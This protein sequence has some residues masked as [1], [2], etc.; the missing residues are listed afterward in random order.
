MNIKSH[1]RLRT[2]RGTAPTNPKFTKLATFQGAT[3]FTFDADK[4]ANLHNSLGSQDP[5]QA[6]GVSSDLIMAGTKPNRSIHERGNSMGSSL[7]GNGMISRLFNFKTDSKALLDNGQGPSQISIDLALLHDAKSRQ[8]QAS[9]WA[10]RGSDING[11]VGDMFGNGELLGV[12][13]SSGVDTFVCCITIRS[14]FFE[15]TS[16]AH[17]LSRRSTEL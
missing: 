17:F 9:G 7:F 15:S 3:Y 13:K 14:F 2:S 16:R 6:Q 12:G 10:Q 11:G 1:Q 5:I 8:L 4:N